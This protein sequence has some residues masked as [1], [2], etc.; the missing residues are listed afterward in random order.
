MLALFG[1]N[2]R[3][4]PAMLPEIADFRVGPKSGDPWAGRLPNAGPV[5]AGN[6]RPIFV[7]MWPVGA[8]GPFSG[9][10][11]AGN[12]LWNTRR[13]VISGSKSPGISDIWRLS[14]YVGATPCR[15]PV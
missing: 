15:S 10:V 9:P 7:A 6:S 5:F 12:P 1:G 4:S 8:V 13:G 14:A 3:I 11:F 2:F